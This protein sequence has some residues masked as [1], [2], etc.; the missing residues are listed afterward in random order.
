MAK[1]ISSKK[2]FPDVQRVWQLQFKKRDFNI[3]HHLIGLKQWQRWKKEVVN[4]PAEL[5]E[6]MK[7]HKKEYLKLAE[8]W[9]KTIPK[10]IPSQTFE[11]WRDSYWISKEIKEL[12]NY[13]YK[14]LFINES[15]PLDQAELPSSFM[16]YHE[17]LA[18][19]LYNYIYDPNVEPKHGDNI[20][21]VHTAYIP[22]VDKFITFDS[23]FSKTLQTSPSLKPKCMSFEEFNQ[24]YLIPRRSL[25]W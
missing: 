19:L 9:S 8:K 10:G 17:Y 1:E 23:E 7:I 13:E 25:H 20:D 22:F 24:N 11:T 12:I 21:L 18:A 16:S 6:F 14:K 3:D 15:L 5:Y 4:A 2:M